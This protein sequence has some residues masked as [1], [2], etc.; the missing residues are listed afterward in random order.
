MNIERLYSITNSNRLTI[1][2]NNASVRFKF[3]KQNTFEENLLV[4][5]LFKYILNSFEPKDRTF[6]GHINTENIKT[7]YYFTM[8]NDA[9]TSYKHYVIPAVSILEGNHA[10]Q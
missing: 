6:R 3:A 8:S 2:A 10:D 7:G 5:A 1:T 9:K 4:E